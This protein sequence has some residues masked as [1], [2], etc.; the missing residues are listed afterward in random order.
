[1]GAVAT[2]TPASDGELIFAMYS[3]N[4]LAC[5]D[6]DGN[7]HWFRGLASD[8]PAT[9]NDVG[10]ASSPLVIGETVV[11]QCEN[12]GDSFVAGI[13]KRTGLNLWQIDR[14]HDAIW[15]SPTLLRGATEKDDVVLLHGR[16]AL[17]GHEPLTG[18]EIFR[19]EASLHTIA[20]VTTRGNRIYVPANGLHVLEYDPEERDVELLWYEQRLR[21]GNSSPVVYG[22]RVFRVRNPAI[23]SC[24][25]VHDGRKLWDV[26]LKGAVWATPLV[27]AEYAYVASYDGD[28]FVVRLG[29][30]GELL[31]TNP[32]G[33]GVLASP[34]AVDGALYLR[35]DTQ[36]LKCVVQ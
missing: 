34:I 18:Q 13:D 9:R 19:Y 22:E 12:Q 35:N 4:D 8:F 17:T 7:L 10:M 31:S 25:D 23:L 15:S 2:N 6:V 20:S 30:K 32:L 5:F 3:S 29:E 1:M 14:D 33:S 26:R 11:V 16:S 28:V 21:G 36:L 27:T 24:A